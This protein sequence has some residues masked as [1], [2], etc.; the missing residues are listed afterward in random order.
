MKLLSFPSFVTEPVAMVALSAADENL[1]QGQAGFA[2]L[3]WSANRCYSKSV[4]IDKDRFQIW[5]LPAKRI[6]GI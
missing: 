6:N 5:L 2:Y 4:T 1:L 3:L